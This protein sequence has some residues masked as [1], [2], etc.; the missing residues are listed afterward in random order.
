MRSIDTTT[1]NK[2]GVFINEYGNAEN[3]NYGLNT[4]KF[5]DKDTGALL[6][7]Q[8]SN[9]NDTGYYVYDGIILKGTLLMVSMST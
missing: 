6:K 5:Y 7:Q 1:G 9:F 3:P 8:Y 4:V 2:P